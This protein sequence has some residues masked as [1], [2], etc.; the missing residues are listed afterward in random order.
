MNLLSLDE[1]Q[2]EAVRKGL[3]KAEERR[4]SLPALA[5]FNIFLRV[6][7][8]FSWLGLAAQWY[9]ETPLVFDRFVTFGIWWCILIES[10]SITFNM[11][12]WF[13]GWITKLAIEHKE[14]DCRRHSDDMHEYMTHLLSFMG[15]QKMLGKLG[16]YFAN[17]NNI[18]LT[19]FLV[20]TGWTFA[21]AII[22]IITLSSWMMVAN[23][24]SWLYAYYSTLT[25]E[26][27]PIQIARGNV[28]SDIM[29]SE[30]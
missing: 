14:E 8:F 24:R 15:P 18:M 5:W 2:R 30:N 10:I 11:V 17:F 3:V 1:F 29:N 21:A 12:M 28:F 25:P 16:V 4:E 19:V 6:T 23:V 26:N 7:F 27:I 9:A 13:L 20:M 22:A